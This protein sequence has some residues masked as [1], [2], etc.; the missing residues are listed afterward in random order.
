MFRLN[1]KTGAVAKTKLDA[2]SHVT[3]SAA[4]SPDGQL[5]AAGD[6][7]KVLLWKMASAG[8]QPRTLG[9][10]SGGTV[11]KV[12]FS[13]DAKQ[14]L[15]GTKGIVGIWDLAT[16]NR[17]TEAQVGPIGYVQTF[18]VSADGKR[19]ASILS[20]ARQ[21]LKVFAMPTGK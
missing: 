9:A 18:A 12:G 2:G 19:L 17:V 7:Y 20:M 11:W 10:R 5:L 21:P 8:E 16:G 4:F 6:G 3:Q 13:P 1:L 15:T 14:L